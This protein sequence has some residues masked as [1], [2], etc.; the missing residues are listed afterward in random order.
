M[1]TIKRHEPR[2]KS[3]LPT[4]STDH[5]FS[6]FSEHLGSLFDDIFL[7]SE[8]MPFRRA[9]QGFFMPRVD[10]KENDKEITVSVE[11]PGLDEKDIEVTLS[12]DSLTIKGE[13]KEEIEDKKENYYRLERLYGTFQ[14]V[15]PLPV[16]VDMK[17]VD[18]SFKKG[19]LHVKL[20]KTAQAKESVRKIAIK[21]EG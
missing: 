14:R 7:G 8:S 12:G 9:E 4:L 15:I 6:L 20:P 11:L 3:L 19:I 2:E 16:E 13:K 21:N 18:A 10:L 5:P 1:A 17:K